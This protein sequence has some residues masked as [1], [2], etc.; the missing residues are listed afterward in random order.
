MI[1]AKES[2][3]MGA[4]HSTHYF[5]YTCTCK[6]Y[7]HSYLLIHMN[8]VYSYTQLQNRKQIKAINNLSFSLVLTLK[9][10]LVQNVVIRES[11]IK[12]ASPCFGAD[13]V[14]DLTILLGR[15]KIKP[16]K[17]MHKKVK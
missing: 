1:L 5:L 4:L 12:Y 8:T 17:K 16:N 13:K 6:M 3:V 15:F 10:R 14:I 7:I 9:R 11:R 2:T